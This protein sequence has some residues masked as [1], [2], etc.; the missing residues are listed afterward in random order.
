M[1]A[2]VNA[3]ITHLLAAVPTLDA[4]E[5]RSALDVAVPINVRGAARFLEELVAHLSTLALSCQRNQIGQI[6]RRA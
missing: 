6:A 5:A 4:N 2:A 1:D 3:A